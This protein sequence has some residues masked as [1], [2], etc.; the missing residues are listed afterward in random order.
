[1]FRQTTDKFYAYCQGCGSISS[2]W[3]K[4]QVFV[5][6]VAVEAA[7]FRGSGS[8]ER[9]KGTATATTIHNIERQNLNVAQFSKKYTTKGESLIDH[10][11]RK[12][13]FKGLWFM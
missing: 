8:W 13:M 6:A 3:W 7:S 2:K 5:K 9:H 4:R 10:H 1:M 11:F 12:N